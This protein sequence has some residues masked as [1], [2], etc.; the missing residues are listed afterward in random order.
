MCAEPTI[1]PTGDH[2]YLINLDAEE[3]SPITLRLRANEST[4]EAIGADVDELSL[5]IATV[6]FLTQ[7]QSADELPAYLDLQ[8][9]ADAY[10]GYIGHIRHQLAK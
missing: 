7:R 5:V 6:D 10:D 3:G 9:V 2:E 4:L 1:E 8:D